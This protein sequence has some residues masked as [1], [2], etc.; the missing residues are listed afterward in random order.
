MTRV[1]RPGD[2]AAHRSGRKG[3]LR[4]TFMATHTQEMIRIAAAAIDEF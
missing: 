1:V 4:L 2:P 3:R